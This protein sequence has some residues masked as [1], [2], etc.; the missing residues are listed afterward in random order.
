[1][2]FYIEGINSRA[3]SR[4]SVAAGQNN[5]YKKRWSATETV[6]IIKSGI[7]SSTPPHLFRLIIR[8]VRYENGNLV[9]FHENEGVELHSRR[10]PDWL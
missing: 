4:G 7:W 1:M 3:A 10:Q 9:K 8:S 2:I 6:I 5:P